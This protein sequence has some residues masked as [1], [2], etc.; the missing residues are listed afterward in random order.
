[1]STNNPLQTLANAQALRQAEAKYR[2]AVL[3]TPYGF[4]PERADFD[5]M[6]AFLDDP[7]RAFPAPTESI[8]ASL[9]R[10]VGNLSEST[11]L[12]GAFA[13]QG[14][15]PTL[16]ADQLFATAKANVTNPSMARAA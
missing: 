15:E 11:A 5:R 3:F 10:T 1:M 16:T 12:L 7:Y 8:K 2:L 14:I 6:D 9:D 4:Q 13:A